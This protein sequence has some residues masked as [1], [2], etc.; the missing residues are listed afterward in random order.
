MHVTI[1]L[2]FVLVNMRNLVSLAFDTYARLSGL[3][4]LGVILI[5]L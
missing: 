5:H 3:K 2:R 4:K 1:V